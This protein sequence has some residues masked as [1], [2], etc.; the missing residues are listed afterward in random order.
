MQD[1]AADHLHVEMAHAEYAATGLAHDG[2]CLRQQVIQRFALFMAAAE[3]AGPG[4]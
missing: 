3:L 2:E 4:L 1:H